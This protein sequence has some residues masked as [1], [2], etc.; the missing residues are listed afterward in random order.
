MPTGYHKR[1]SAM[2]EIFDDVTRNI[3]QEREDEIKHP[4]FEGE[5]G[6]YTLIADGRVDMI[7]GYLEGKPG[8]DAK[9][10]GVLSENPL[11]NAMYH[12]VAMTTML[13]RVC[14]SH[15]LDQEI[16]YKMSD[17]FIQKADRLKTPE[18]VRNLQY[19]LMFQYATT[20]GSFRK[21]H[22]NSRQ[23]V[24]CIDYISQ[25]L[26]EKITMEALAEYVQLNETYL[27]KLFKKE[28]GQSVSE[29]I[30]DRKVEEAAALLRYSEKTSVEIA[31]D[32]GFSSHSYFISIFKKVMGM[33][34]KEYRDQYFRKL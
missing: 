23:I 1:G 25:H 20:M 2:G 3:F 14:I 11:R 4:A 15:G 13:T 19:Q 16:A 29:Y 7:A 26:H 32:L 21:L 28:T 18:E 17:A 24:R 6:L 8:P 10:R 12:F 27:S 33:T 31:T 5:M 34:P 30:R 9:E 22:V